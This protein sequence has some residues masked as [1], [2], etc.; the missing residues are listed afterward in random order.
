MVEVDNPNVGVD[1]R[2]C[3]SVL[4]KALQMEPVEI[5]EQVTESGLRG[6]GGA[7]FPTGQKWQICRGAPGKLKYLI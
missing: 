6:R 4:A 7:G 5:I 2:D 3:R 1:E